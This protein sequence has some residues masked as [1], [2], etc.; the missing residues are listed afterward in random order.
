MKFNHSNK[1]IYLLLLSSL[2]FLL[3]P[4]KFPV[5]DGFFYPQIAFNVVHSH[6]LGF[7]D[8]YITNGFHPLW[9]LV[10][11]FGE[12]I[13]PFGKEF[14]LNIL[15]FFQLIF[16]FVGFFLLQKKFLLNNFFGEI[17]SI[18]FLCI[19]FFSLGALYLTEAHLVFFTLA[20]LLFYSTKNRLNDFLFGFI[21][22]LIFLARLDHVFI[23]FVFLI[24]YWNV[25]KW[26][27]RS[28]INLFL[29]FGVL[30]IPY[31]LYNF[32]WFNDFVPIS[33]KIKSTFPRIQENIGFTIE[34]KIFSIT[35]MFYLL[36]LFLRKEVSYRII[37]IVF[38]V[39][40]L[41]QLTFNLLFQSAVG[42]WYFVSQI[43]FMALFIFDSTLLFKRIKFA[44]PYSKYFLLIGCT[45]VVLGIG[46]VKLTT[47]FGFHKNF[48][49]NQSSGENSEKTIK[50]TASELKK[51]LPSESR[52]YM[53]DFPGQFAFY[54]DFNVIPIDGLVGNENYFNEINNY[55]L[56]KFLIKNRIEYMLLPFYLNKKNDTVS[57]MAIKVTGYQEKAK[58]DFKNTLS[59]TFFDSISTSGKDL[60]PVVSLDNSVKK[61]QSD[62]DSLK[63]FKLRK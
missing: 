2:F 61:W 18:C 9:L 39:G 3:N 12:Y 16:V 14:L 29:G 44:L 13:N 57:L 22:S 24:W 45:T 60:K 34:Q 38:V 49:E 51:I 8:L 54:S 46:Y 36:F 20:L 21:L 26:T 5:D 62:Y 10:A 55:G 48:T 23:V 27:F 59:K 25:K 33:G 30:S 35:G 31:L 7:N 43:L 58:Y 47:G 4:A 28:L 15:W 41:L 32:F 19:V 50:E 42:Q 52:I 1:A 63:V 17:L 56:K 6:Y 53:Y 40:S 37:K 11:V